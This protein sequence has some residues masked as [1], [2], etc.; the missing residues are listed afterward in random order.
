MSLNTIIRHRTQEKELQLAGNLAMT[1]N[2]WLE[3]GGIYR[4]T[5][6]ESKQQDYYTIRMCEKMGQ[7]VSAE[8]LQQAKDFAMCKSYYAE[9]LIEKDGK[10]YVPC[11]PVFFRKIT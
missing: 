4:G 8:E 10:R 2:E 7:S 9:Y 5:L 6:G 11:V 1:K 3:K